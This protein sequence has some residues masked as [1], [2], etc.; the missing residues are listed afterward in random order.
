ML[1]SLERQKGRNSLLDARV[2]TLIEHG[3]SAVAERSE[4][5]IFFKLF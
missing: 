4:I 1:T 2:T 3:Q 5:D